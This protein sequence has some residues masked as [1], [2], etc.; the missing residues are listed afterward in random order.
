MS[1]VCVYMNTTIRTIYF[2]SYLN[3][4]LTILKLNSSIYENTIIITFN[5]T[6]NFYSISITLYSTRFLLNKSCLLSLNSSR[7]LINTIYSFFITN[8]SIRY[9]NTTIR[10][11]YFTIYR[12]TIRTVFKLNTFIY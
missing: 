5:N 11:I 7:H 12:N 6:I 3:T 8:S 9:I 10:T 2:T 4:I 1:N